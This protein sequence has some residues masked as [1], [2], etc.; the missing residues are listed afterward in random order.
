MKPLGE[1]RNEL[2]KKK[3]S[4]EVGSTW[5]EEDEKELTDLDKKMSDLSAEYQKVTDDANKELNEYKEK[6]INE[7]QGAAFLLDDAEYDLVG[8]YCWF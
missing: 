8:W 5:G 6:R 3:A 1:R 7:E 2:A 4:T